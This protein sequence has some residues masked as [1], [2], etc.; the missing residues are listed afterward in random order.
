MVG[1]HDMI[2]Q[3][4]AEDLTCLGQSLVMQ[5]VFVLGVILHLPKGHHA[6]SKTQSD[7]PRE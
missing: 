1:D 4:D 6:L 3:F 7:C 2:A 5:T